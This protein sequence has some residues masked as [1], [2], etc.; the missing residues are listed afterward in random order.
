MIISRN[1]VS[2]F[3]KIETIRSEFPDKVLNIP[4]VEKPQIKSKMKVL[5]PA[6]E[7]QI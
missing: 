7:G 6:M 4:S 1:I 3:F 5:Y 2:T